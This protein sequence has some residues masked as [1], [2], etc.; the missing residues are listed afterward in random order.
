MTQEEKN[1]LIKYLCA[2]LPYGLMMGNKEWPRK[3][4]QLT[5]D[6]VQYAMMEDDWDDVP[7]LRPISSMTK[8]EYECITP[9][10][11]ERRVT[12]KA[13]GGFE[14]NKIKT[15]SLELIGW[16]L[17]HHF[18]FRGLIDKGLAIE[19]TDKNNPYKD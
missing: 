4:Y 1:L 16:L 18:D 3:P 2:A 6:E 11:G 14:L 10:L 9:M 12:Y 8:E 19:V 13:N 5:C 7:F 15:C 17:A